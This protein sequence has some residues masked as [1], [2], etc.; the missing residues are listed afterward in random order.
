M[1]YI[2]FNYQSKETQTAI[3]IV[4]TIIKQLVSGIE[5][6]EELDSLYK[7]SFQENTIPGMKELI[8]LLQSCSNRFSSKYAIF[9]ALDECCDTHKEGIL[10]LFVNLQIL[11]YRLLISGRPPLDASRFSNVSTLEIRATDHDIETYILKKLEER[12]VRT[13]IKIGC[14]EL[15]KGVDGM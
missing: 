11:G 7:T 14:L 4:K 13:K 15:V 9:D 12:D 3:Q 5:I 2:Y 6:P 8:P 10:D 1:V